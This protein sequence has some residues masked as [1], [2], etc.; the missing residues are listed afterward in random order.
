MAAFGLCSLRL[1]KVWSNF[2]GFITGTRPIKRMGDYPIA[3]TGS[4]MIVTSLI[5]S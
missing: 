1:L 4:A 5:S 2:V 3:K